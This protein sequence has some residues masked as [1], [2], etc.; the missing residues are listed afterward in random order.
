MRMIPSGGYVYLASPYSH[1][2]PFVREDRYLRTMKYMSRALAAGRFVYSP[3]VH[4]HELAKVAD[5]PRD[6]KFWEAYNFTMLDAATELW[7]LCLPDWDLSLGVDGEVQHAK[8]IPIP[9]V[10]LNPEGEIK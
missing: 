3:I 7:V 9:V 4:C 8:S 10:Y 5:L 6:A 2:D 1:D